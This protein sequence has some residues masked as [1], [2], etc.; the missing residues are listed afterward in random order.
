MN[1]EQ[2]LDGRISYHESPTS[3]IARTLRGKGYHIANHAGVRVSEPLQDV[4][5]ILE[6]KEPIKKSF[7]RS[8]LNMEKRDLYIGT[9]FVDK[10]SIGARP[11]ENWILE[12]YGR[13]NVPKLTELVRE[14]S[15]PR[16][17]SVQVR[18]ISDQP[19]VEREW[20]DFSM[21]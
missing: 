9:L 16:N 17:V 12:V 15:E 10:E 4:L 20:S 2:K 5:G 8:I 13:D 11:D 6:P 18:L 14:H 21:Y 7:L 1:M 19:R 3:G